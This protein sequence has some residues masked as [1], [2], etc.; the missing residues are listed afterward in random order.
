MLK[1]LPCLVVHFWQT[2][3]ERKSLLLAVNRLLSVVIF[4]WDILYI[5]STLS[6]RGPCSGQGAD[7]KPQPQSVSALCVAKKLIFRCEFA[8]CRKWSSES[9]IIWRFIGWP[10][11]VEDT[12]RSIDVTFCDSAMSLQAKYRT[13]E[14]TIDCRSTPTS[15]LYIL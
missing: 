15:C 2:F 1:F 12:I 14:A 3:I 4:L 5:A 7:P 6:R 11:I 13:H 8:Y 9:V 10:V